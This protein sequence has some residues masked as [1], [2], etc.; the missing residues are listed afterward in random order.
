[1][2]KNKKVLFLKAIFS[3]V[4]FV[5]LAS[6]VQGR[7]FLVIFSHINWLY[8]VLSFVLIPVMLSTSCFKWKILLDAGGYNVSFLRLIAIYLVGYF[9]SNFLP[10]T[11][12]GDV[13]RSFYA[14]KEINNQSYSAV[15]V[16]IER[17]SGIMFLFILVILTFLVKSS[18]YGNLY[19]LIP[20]LCSCFLL[21]AV[22][23]MWKVKDPF[24]LPKS[25]VFALF[26][27]LECLQRRV[28]SVLLGKLLTFGERFLHA[29]FLRLEKFSGELRKAFQIIRTD[30]ALLC[31][32]SILTVL[33]YFLTWV[34]IY[35][36]FLAFG[37]KVDFVAIIT[38]VPTI[39]FVAHLPVTVLGNLGFFESVFVVYFL[40]IGVPSAETLA[41]GLLLRLKMLS[42]GSVGF[43]VYLFYQKVRGL[44][45]A[46][47]EE[48]F[49]EA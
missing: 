31:K 46:E 47:K 7:E 44:V 38:L 19:F 20:A 22:I 24:L 18:F 33:F 36:A 49:F 25:I 8:F 27:W 3:I 37:K 10:S 34:N 9:F 29:L 48:S 6:F 41:M 12:G 13:V 35:V 15:A 2:K 28:Q 5:V 23:W 16:F 11:V 1:M 39:M 45:P 43:V 40:L 32:I 26:S 4:F 42:L 14:G 21:F 17:F 30:R